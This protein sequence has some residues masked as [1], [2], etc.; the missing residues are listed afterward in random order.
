MLKKQNQMIK[1]TFQ[2]KCDEGLQ[3]M[4]TLSGLIL[5]LHLNFFFPG[6]EIK[7]IPWRECALLFLILHLL[8]HWREI[9]LRKAIF[10]IR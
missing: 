8:G 10:Y 3:I 7:A 6:L 1:S 5:L 4:K 9:S 2:E